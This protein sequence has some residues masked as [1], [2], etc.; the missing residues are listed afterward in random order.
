MWPGANIWPMPSSSAVSTPSRKMVLSWLIIA[1]VLSKARSRRG[2]SDPDERAPFRIQTS[3]EREAPRR[4]SQ[5][6]GA[7]EP[8]QLAEPD[9]QHRRQHHHRGEREQQQLVVA[10]RHVREVHPEE[11]GQE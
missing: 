2:Y 8:A 7:A 6:R 4:A 3:F 1:N 9:E 5:M 10:E 11:A